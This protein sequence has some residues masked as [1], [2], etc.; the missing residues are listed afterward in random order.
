MG[1]EHDDSLRC[2]HCSERLGLEF[3]SKLKDTH[4]ISFSI[5]PKPGEMICAKTLG[6]TTTQFGK[7][8]EAIGKDLGAKTQVLV[9]RIAT[10]ETGQHFIHC[11]ITRVAPFGTRKKGG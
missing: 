9:E 2:P 3:V 4:R 10:D 6:G 11:L 1:A 5:A 7:L 8:L